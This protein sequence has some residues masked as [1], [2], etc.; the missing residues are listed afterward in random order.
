MNDAQLRAKLASSVERFNLPMQSTAKDRRRRTWSEGRCQRYV[1]KEAGYGFV[2][3]SLAWLFLKP[4]II[5]LIV[6]MAKKLFNKINDET[7]V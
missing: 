7:K 1:A 4:L 3:W 5:S 6:E 2:S